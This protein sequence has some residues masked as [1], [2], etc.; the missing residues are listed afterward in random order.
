M[1]STYEHNSFT[2]NYIYI[3]C[4]RSAVDLPQFIG[5]NK[6]G[7]PIK[8]FDNIHD[9]ENCVNEISIGLRYIVSVPLHKN[10]IQQHIPQIIYNIL[11]QQPNIPQYNYPNNQKIYPSYYPSAPLPI[12]NDPNLPRYN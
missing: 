12:H 3:V 5:S 7:T 1:N 2:P 10:N 4:E 11:P 9:A 6:I 8:A